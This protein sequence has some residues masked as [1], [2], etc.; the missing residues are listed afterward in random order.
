MD[1]GNH[2]LFHWILLIAVA[3]AVPIVPF[4][5]FGESAES[6]TARWLNFSDSRGAAAV[7]VIGLLAGDIV[8]PVP[9]SIVSTFAG[10]ALG[11]WLGTAASWCGMTIGASAA[12]WLV[13]WFGRP[14]A[15]RLSS[16]EELARMDA[17]AARHGILILILARPIPVLAEA[18]VLVIGTM[19]I[20][21][22]R[23]FA[24]IGLSNLGIAA[25]YAALGDRVELP[26]AMAAAIAVPVV[27]AIA[28][29]WLWPSAKD[30]AS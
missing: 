17:L 25:A 22:W 4:L 14:L 2:R 26:I 21:W 13:R 29:R 30:G 16:E 11:F 27:V 7:L 20:G 19:R 15:R 24:A 3:L 9:S 5:V 28:A 1:A 6:K 12:Y 18:S 10:K 23:F 8:L